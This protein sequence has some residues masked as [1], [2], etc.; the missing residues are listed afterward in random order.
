MLVY[1]SS[2]LRTSAIQNTSIET[3]EEMPPPEI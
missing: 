3:S 1:L 2:L